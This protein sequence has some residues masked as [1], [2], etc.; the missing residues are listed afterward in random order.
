[1]NPYWQ[2]GAIAFMVI[3]PLYFFYHAMDS[4][5]KLQN[6]D[7]NDDQRAWYEENRKSCLQGGILLI[8]V[9]LVGLYACL[10]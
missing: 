7:L 1:M 3:S 4:N 5:R 9:Y 2:I 8:V 6:P 10:S